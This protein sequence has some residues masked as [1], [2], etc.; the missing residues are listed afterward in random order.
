MKVVILAGGRGTRIAE[1]TETIPKPMVEI[2]GKPILW[3]IMKIYSSYGFNEFIICLGYKG[4]VIKEYFSHYFLHMSDV[5]IDLTNNKLDIHSTASEPWK[6]TL[7]DTGLETM[8]GARIKKI[9]KYV[10]D[11]TFMLTYGDGFADINIDNLLSEHRK[12]NKLATLTAIQ[13]A[14]KFGILNIGK[15]NAVSSFLEKPKGESSWINGGFFVLEPKVFE[16]IKNGDSA[17]WESD[18]LVGLA[19][20]SKLFAYKHTGFWRC[21]DTLR[22]KVELEKLW[23][24]NQALWKVWR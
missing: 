9:Q 15:N 19:Q 7:V 22:D 20:D 12:N 17:I 21:L 2:G 16:Y 4:Y 24:T 1:E 5:T 11:E 10:N 23:N 3:H 6:V 14:G 8:T 18:S 13:T